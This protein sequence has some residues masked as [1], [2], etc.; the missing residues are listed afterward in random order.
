[1]RSRPEI[2][3]A[4]T[5]R[6][7]PRK[8][9]HGGAFGIRVDASPRDGHEPDFDLGFHCHRLA[10]KSSMKLWGL[11]QINPLLGAYNLN[12]ALLDEYFDE[13]CSMALNARRYIEIFGDSELATNV[14][15]EGDEK[16]LRFWDALGLIIHGRSF[17]AGY[18]GVPKS[19]ILDEIHSLQLKSLEVAL[20]EDEQRRLNILY[21]DLKKLPP[22]RWDQRL[23]GFRI[24]SDR[25]RDHWVS[26]E[27]MAQVFL[28]QRF[29]KLA[30]WQRSAADFRKPIEE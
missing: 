15:G 6:L 7:P 17:I 30:E 8:F 2:N 13:T 22:M 21:E 5:R 26:V 16:P 24:S 10:L 9:E 3:F 12:D 4:G 25:K 23:V 1:M 28:E 11:S 19:P 20:N 18:F 29:S 27:T 14:V